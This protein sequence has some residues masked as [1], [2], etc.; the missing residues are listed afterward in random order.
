[1]LQAYSASILPKGVETKGEP[2][3]EAILSHGAMDIDNTGELTDCTRGSLG[4]MKGRKESHR[5]ESNAMIQE[6]QPRRAKKMQEIYASDSREYFFGRG[7]ELWLFTISDIARDSQR[8]ALGSDDDQ[9]VDVIL[10]KTAYSNSFF[11][12]LIGVGIYNL[13]RT[14]VLRLFVCMIAQDSFICVC[15]GCCCFERLI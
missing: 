11:S 14:R 8:D 5:D 4:N 10:N 6:R 9:I 1:M 2:V 13:W 12:R 3:V 7:R 15:W